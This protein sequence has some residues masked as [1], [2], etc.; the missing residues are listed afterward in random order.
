MAKLG[1][2]N[3]FTAYTYTYMYICVCIDSRFTAYANKP[4]SGL[5]P[6][7][8]FVHQA[9]VLNGLRACHD[10]PVIQ[11]LQLLAQVHPLMHSHQ[12]CLQRMDSIQMGCLFP[13]VGAVVDLEPWLRGA[14]GCGG[15]FTAGYGKLGLLLPNLHTSAVPVGHLSCNS[16]MM[17][18]AFISTWNP[19]NSWL[20]F[21]VGFGDRKPGFSAFALCFGCN[22][23]HTRSLHAVT[24]YISCFHGPI[25]HLYPTF[26]HCGCGPNLR[27]SRMPGPVALPSQLR[28]VWG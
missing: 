12:F 19:W 2:D 9:H 15:S 24:C 28:G 21:T 6:S 4:P 7:V 27:N 17:V 8:E 11:V 23:R 25:K 3:N 16:G 5:L 22:A 10:L 13:S 14:T 20:T 18:R 26:P 1:P